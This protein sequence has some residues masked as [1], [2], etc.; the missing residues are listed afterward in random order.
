MVM[1]EPA[2][3]RM[4]IISVMVVVVMVTAGV[5]VSNDDSVERTTDDEN[6][7]AAESKTDVRIFSLFNVTG[8]LEWYGGAIITTPSETKE[9]VDARNAKKKYCRRI[10]SIVQAMIL[11]SE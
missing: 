7:D 1:S 9:C 10:Q 11:W 2:M 5:D 6:H 4:M 8:F 3:M